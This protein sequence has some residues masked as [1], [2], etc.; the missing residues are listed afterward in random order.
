MVQQ[1]RYGI[2]DPGRAAEIAAKLERLAA[3]RTR[4]HQERYGRADH[5]DISLPELDPHA[6][7]THRRQRRQRRQRAVEAIEQG[8]MEAP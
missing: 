7:V 8:R 5:G 3:A 6:P 4:Y 2:P 1:V